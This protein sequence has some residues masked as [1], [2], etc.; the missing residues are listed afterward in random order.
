MKMIIKKA[1]STFLAG[2]LTF[3]FVT[4]CFSE[5]TTSVSDVEIDEMYLKAAEFLEDLGI[6]SGD[7]EGDLLLENT[8]TRAELSAMITRILGYDNSTGIYASTRFKDI[9]E[10]HWASGS[11]AMDLM[12]V[13]FILITQLQ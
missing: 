3:S 12:T 9:D 13:C 2:I 10:K 6:L 5:E 11:I 7:D 1:L 4:V 8:V